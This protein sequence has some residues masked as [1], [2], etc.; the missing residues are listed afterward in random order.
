M[1]EQVEH[2]MGLAA[3]SGKPTNG[4]NGSH[5]NKSS[6]A[7]KTSRFDP[8]FTDAVIN[9]TGPKASPRLRKVM[10]SLTRHLHDFCRENEITIDEYMAGVE[11]IN[12]AGRMSDLKRNEGQLLT[13]VI[14]LETLVDEITYT[15]A[16]EATD[17]PTATA[18][19]GPFWRQDSPI[20]KMG[21][22][23][24]QNSIPDG[25]HTFLHGRVLDFNT[26]KPIQNAEI[27]IWHTAPNGLYEQQDPEQP[28][29]NLRG[30]FYTGEDGAY[31]FYCLRPTSYPV[32][33]DGPAGKL[34]QLLDRHPMRPAH[35]HFILTAE[36]Y[37][38]L[39]TQ[40]FD[41]RDKY[42]DNDVVF[43]VKDSLV[44]DFLPKKGDEKAQFDLE[45]DFKLVGYGVEKKGGM[46][47][48]TAVAP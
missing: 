40:I 27:D 10:A 4:T 19:L 34:I 16:S 6:D 20:Y 17:A 15:L 33:M 22:S 9:A 28:D 26:G 39:T 47:G 38:P 37:K 48:A 2:P 35:I 3:E 25:D 30:R 36:G 43:A 29:M 21:S 8:A 31:S 7:V 24:I 13:D 12:W 46:E 23:I 1:A 32:P 18:I 41:R 5:T 45:Y 14:G 42:I 11:M 44:V